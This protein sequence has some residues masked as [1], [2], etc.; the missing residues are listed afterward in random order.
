MEKFN[1]KKVVSSMNDVFTSST[2]VV[3][4]HYKGLTVSEVTSLR[5]RMRTLGASFKVTKN[6]LVKLSLAD[7][8]FEPLSSLFT[9][10]TAIAFSDDPV[11]AAKGMVEFSKENDK[12]I[13]LGGMI[14]AQIMNQTQVQ[15]LATLPSIDELR[16]KIIG[17]INTPATR[18]AS[19]VQAPA[20][21]LARVFGAY[22]SKKD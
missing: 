3:V 14:N 4:A 2:T 11:S 7:T 16:S 13:I 18:I 6:S 9:G 15:S 21:K 8:Q 19:V 10:P 5:R 12:L 20:G 22:A 1:K 17:I